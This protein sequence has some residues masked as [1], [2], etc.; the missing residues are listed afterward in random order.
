MDVKQYLERINIKTIQPANDSFLAQLHLN[1]LMAVPFENLDIRQ[2]IRIVLAEKKFY[3]KIVHRRRGGF[4]YELNGLFRRLLAEL[5]F[6]VSIASGRVY[7]ASDDRFSPEF[8]HM[9]L[10]VQMDK[11]I[12]VDVGFGDCFRKPIALP[13]GST[14]DVS[15]RYRITPPGAH[16]DVYILERQEK[17]A[18]CPVY[19]F[20]SAPRQL[21]DFTEICDFNQSSPDSHFTQQTIC[22]IATENGRVTLT[23]NSLAITEDDKE[24]NVPVESPEMFQQLL[25]EIFNISIDSQPIHRRK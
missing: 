13:D 23:E 6:S 8:D 22:S 18:W 1:H 16:K 2:G 9:V 15:G 5:G 11:T 19:S 12:L 3:E 20:T 25:V 7:I 4:C 14:E 24:R 17:G 21:L 10:L